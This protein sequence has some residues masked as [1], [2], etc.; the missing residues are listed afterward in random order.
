VLERVK[1]IKL[2]IILIIVQYNKSAKTWT[3]EKYGRE[4]RD[5]GKV[6]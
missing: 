6:N 5:E 4:K 1:K 2:I 3:L